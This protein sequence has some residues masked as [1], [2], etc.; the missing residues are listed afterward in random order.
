MSND[1]HWIRIR[2]TEV[3]ARHPLVTEAVSSRMAEVLEGR[4][5]EQKLSQTELATLASALIA[6]MVPEPPATDSR[7]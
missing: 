3:R 5:G 4:L 2:I 1:D 6:D 7:R